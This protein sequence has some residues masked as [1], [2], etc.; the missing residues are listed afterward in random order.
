MELDLFIEHNSYQKLQYLLLMC[1]YWL[2][3]CSEHHLEN[4][5]T[6][7]YVTKHQLAHFLSLEYVLLQLEIDG[8]LRLRVKIWVGA[9]L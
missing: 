3:F 8:F 2:L 1:S 5:C 7:T 9:L 6:I 4:R